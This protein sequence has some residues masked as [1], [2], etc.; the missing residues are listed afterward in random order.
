MRPHSAIAIE[1]LVA[2]IVVLIIMAPSANQFQAYS[3]SSGQLKEI[4]SDFN[5]EVYI[6]QVYQISEDSQ[7]RKIGLD[8]ICKNQNEQPSICIS[9]SIM[10]V[11]DTNGTEYS[12][13]SSSIRS[14]LRIE[15]GDIIRVNPEFSM[16]VAST[17]SVLMIRDTESNYV[18]DLT[19][20][21]TPEDSVPTSDWELESSKAFGLRDSRIAIDVYNLF[22]REDQISEGI[23][24]LQ[25]YIGLTNLE[26]TPTSFRTSNLY[27]KERSGFVYTPGFNAIEPRLTSGNIDGE[28]SI[29][30]YIS[31]D[32]DYSKDE[33]FMLI[34]DEP[35]K[36]YLH[37]GAY[38]DRVTPIVITPIP[39][40]LESTIQLGS[41]VSFDVAGYDNHDGLIEATCNPSSGSIFTPGTTQVIC[42]ARDSSGNIARSSF[43]VIVR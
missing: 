29:N 18:I 3:T 19:K 36:S 11:R 42:T 34:Y 38:R 23:V 30:G 9:S 21:K 2:A 27:L 31:F 39:I 33:P 43:W 15:E 13:D 4:V 40:V 22:V 41:I 32:F 26:K 24:H 28:S 25:V 1:L 14:S 17:P 7:T 5:R 20:T 35:G 12:P 37:N 8:I 16:P 10:W 6:N